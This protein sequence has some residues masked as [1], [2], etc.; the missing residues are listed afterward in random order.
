MET[1]T[2]TYVI[3]KEY[4]KRWVMLCNNIDRTYN[5]LGGE[6]ESERSSEKGRLNYLLIK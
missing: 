4:R 6:K 3:H 1:N 5:R 2:L